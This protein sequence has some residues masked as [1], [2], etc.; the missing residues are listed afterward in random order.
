MKQDELD[1]V[2]RLLRHYVTRLA[3][4]PDGELRCQYLFN[5]NDIS[6]TTHKPMLW[7]DLAIATDLGVSAASV[8][9]ARRADYGLAFRKP[10]FLPPMP[11]TDASP[12]EAPIP[13]P[14]VVDLPEAATQPLEH[15]GDLFKVQ[16]MVERI[17]ILEIKMGALRRDLYGVHE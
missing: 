2:K 7:T 12:P 15:L 6:P 16:S 17:L 8:R 1:R 9:T 5:K 10:R 11:D 3:D 13:V 4:W 14:V